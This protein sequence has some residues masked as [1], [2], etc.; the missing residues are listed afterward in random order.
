MVL[1]QMSHLQQHSPQSQ[2]LGRI[3]IDF[4][5]KNALKCWSLTGKINI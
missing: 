3:L 2:I 4:R 1:L 5:A